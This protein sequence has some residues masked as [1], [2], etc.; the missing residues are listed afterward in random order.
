MATLYEYGLQ[1]IGSDTIVYFTKEECKHIEF[2]KNCFT[3]L[4]GEWIQQEDM[5]IDIHYLS[6]DDIL[7]IKEFVKIRVRLQSAPR[8]RDIPLEVLK[9]E[10]LDENKKGLGYPVVICPPLITAENMIGWDPISTGLHADYIEY[11]QRFTGGDDNPNESDKLFAFMQYADYLQCD[12]LLYLL[13]ARASYLLVHYIDKF[14]RIYYYNVFDIS[15]SDL[16]L[17][18]FEWAKIPNKDNHKEHVFTKHYL[19]FKQMHIYI[20]KKMLQR[21]IRHRSLDLPREDWTKEQWQEFKYKLPDFYK[22]N[23]I[24]LNNGL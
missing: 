3:G 15:G 16:I 18:F 13:Q 24:Q 7:W 21:F 19:L 17:R 2:T 23:N 9:T 11:L 22:K 6:T 8:I 10:L 4:S 20:I 12:D 5:A 1:A 14:K